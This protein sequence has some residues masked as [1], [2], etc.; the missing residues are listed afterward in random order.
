MLVNNSAICCFMHNK[1]SNGLFLFN[2]TG[3]DVNRSFL[4]LVRN[5]MGRNLH[6]DVVESLTI[7]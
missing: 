2:Q 3:D 5:K 4:I 1:H 7:T 6:M